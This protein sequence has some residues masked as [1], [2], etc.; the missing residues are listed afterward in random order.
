MGVRQR[1]CYPLKEITVL[2]RHAYPAHTFMRLSAGERE[3]GGC[4]A[5][6]NRASLR[7]VSA[8]MLVLVYVVL[9]VIDDSG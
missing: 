3:K 2:S 8:S 1:D 9:L 5:G 7:I 4:V 6:F